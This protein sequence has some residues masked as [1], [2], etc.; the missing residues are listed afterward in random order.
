MEA[1]ARALSHLAFH[2]NIASMRLDN[3]ARDGKPQPCPSCAAVTGLLTS[4]KTFEDVWDVLGA[5]A[6]ASIADGHFHA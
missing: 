5:D 1:K 4:I 2:L 3:A 6:F